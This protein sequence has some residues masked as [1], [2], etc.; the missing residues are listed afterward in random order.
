[1]VFPSYKNTLDRLTSIAESIDFSL[2]ANFAAWEIPIIMEGRS[3]LV[4][5][6]GTDI[7]RTDHA[8]D[9]RAALPMGRSP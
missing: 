5:S 8:T 4:F 6:A 9:A 3:S 1:L 7:F 2:S